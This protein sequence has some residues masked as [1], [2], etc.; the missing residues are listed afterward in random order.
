MTHIMMSDK[1]GGILGHTNSILYIS[2]HFTTTQ[3]ESNHREFTW[4]L[5]LSCKYDDPS[6][7]SVL[8]YSLACAH[9]LIS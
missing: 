5:Y 7:A 6:Y 2:A 8:S 3:L 9:W 1:G 4:E